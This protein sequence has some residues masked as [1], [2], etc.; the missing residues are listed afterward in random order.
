MKPMTRV[1][2]PPTAVPLC[3]CFADKDWLMTSNPRAQEV[4]GFQG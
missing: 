2:Q 3:R 4:K 1:A